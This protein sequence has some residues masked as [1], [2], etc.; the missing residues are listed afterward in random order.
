MTV[1]ICVSDGGGVLFGGRRLARDREVISDIA[2]T[3]GDE[4]VFVSEY[5]EGLFSN[6]DV[7]VIAVSDPISSAGEGDFAF[8]EDGKIRREIGRVE[9]V[10]IYRWNRKYPFDTKVDTEPGCEGFALA[11]SVDIKGYSHEKITKEIWRRK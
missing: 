3:A 2:R 11:E 9:S 8:I 5:S 1:I 7:S 4:P 10:I 6:S